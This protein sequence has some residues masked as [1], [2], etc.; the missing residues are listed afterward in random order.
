MRMLQPKARENLSF[1]FNI[2][3]DLH[4]PLHGYKVQ[5]QN[6]LEQHYAHFNSLSRHFAERTLHAL[7]IE[8]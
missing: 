3:R 1:F 8:F 4:V 2:A 6:W 5:M 7:L